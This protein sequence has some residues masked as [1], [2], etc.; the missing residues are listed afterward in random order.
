MHLPTKVTCGP[1]EPRFAFG[2]AFGVELANQALG[3][4]QAKVGGDFKIVQTEV[5]KCCDGANCVAAVQTAHRETHLMHRIHLDLVDARYL[6]FDW[7][8]KGDNVTVAEFQI[9]QQGIESSGLAAAGRPFHQKHTIG[10]V[11]PQTDPFNTLGRN[12][13]FLDILGSFWR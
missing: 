10:S 1:A 7:I 2:P 8:F 11:D 9:V 3:G 5:A 12:A 13:Q 6:V 4:H